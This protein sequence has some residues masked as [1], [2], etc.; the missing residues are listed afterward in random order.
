MQNLGPTTT[1][2]AATWILD[3]SLAFALDR[4]QIRLLTA[5]SEFQ[6]FGSPG[7]TGPRIIKVPAYLYRNK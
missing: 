4:I 5:L 2:A 1:L 3:E 7:T 6:T